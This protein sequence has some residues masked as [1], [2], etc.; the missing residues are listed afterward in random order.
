MTVGGR[1]GGGDCL[2][3]KTRNPMHRL[4]PKM[5]P[6]PI[7]FPIKSFNFFP[8]VLKSPM[9]IPKSCNG[10]NLKTAPLLI[11]KKPLLFGFTDF[12]WAGKNE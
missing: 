7:D 3:K 5:G 8:F 2:E 4:P 11:L 10:L 6:L 12:Q 9:E 1:W